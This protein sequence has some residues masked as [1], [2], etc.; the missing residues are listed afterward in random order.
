[1]TGK[2]VGEVV[3]FGVL[4][5]YL[6]LSFIAGTALVFE[7]AELTALLS[8]LPKVGYIFEYGWFRFAVPAVLLTG[9]VLWFVLISIRKRPFIV[10]GHE[11]RLPTPAVGV[12]QLFVSIADLAIA[13]SVVYV[14][15]PEQHNLAWLAFVG[16]FSVVQFA[17]LMSA[18]PGGVG[19]F[20]AIMVIVLGPRFPSAPELLASLIA[21][22]VIYYM[23][24]FL[25]GGLT[26]LAMVLVQNAR[27]RK[28]GKAPEAGSP[29]EIT[30]P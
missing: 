11:F 16:I 7:G 5:Y 1:M 12:C 8:K 19:V 2:Q 28:A 25:I 22:R 20:T 13:A 4:T 26:F 9:V 14:L 24:P 15:L 23:I 3:G 10:R 17:S 29:Q 18:V 27:A 21:F 6:G 30:N